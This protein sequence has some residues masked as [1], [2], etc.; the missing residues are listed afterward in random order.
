MAYPRFKSLVDETITLMGQVAGSGVQVYSEPLVKLALNRIFDYL[1]EKRKWDH[2]W[3]WKTFN[4]GV[5]G[6]LTTD[7]SGVRD[8][9][10]IA[11][12]RDANTKRAISA[13]V[14]TEHLYVTGS[15]PL[16]RTV[17]PW[18]DPVAETRF[19]QFYP[20]GATAS[21]EMFLGY[22]PDEFVSDDDVVP[23]PKSLML[24]GAVWFMLA[25][26]GTNPASADKFQGLFDLSY[27]NI[28]S[29]LNAQPI[30]HGSGRNRG[31][32]VLIRP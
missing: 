18:N 15:S 30:G 22:R 23:M 13:P 2:L 10:D 16:Y 3:G 4:I 28:V 1:W 24:H 14:E 6:K 26:D 21:V 31:Q 19:F 25:D 7:I 9:I 20:I 27:Q 29:R 8:Y 32:T 11:E 5:D 12:V 17:L